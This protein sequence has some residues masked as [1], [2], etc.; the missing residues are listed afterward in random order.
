MTSNKKDYLADLHSYLV[1]ANSVLITSHK[2][3]DDDSISSVLALKLWIAREYPN[4]LVDIFYE[5]D[6]SQRWQVF[7]GFD[8]IYTV[9]SL[10]GS[11][12]DYDILICTDANQYH[13]LTD[14]PSGLTGYH[15]P[16]ICIDHHKS[17]PDAWDLLILDETAVATAEILFGLLYNKPDKK[18]AKALLLG[19]LG[20]TGNLR[21]IDHSQAYVYDIVKQLVS[22]AKIN[23]QSFKASYDYYS[24]AAI[25]VARHLIANQKTLQIKSW[26]SVNIT[27]VEG[28]SLDYL[29][30]EIKE[31]VNLYIATFSMLQQEVT[32]SIV[33]YE[34]EKGVNISARSIPESVNVRKFMENLGIGSGHDRAAGGVWQG[35]SYSARQQVEYLE[36]WLAS[37]PP[38]FD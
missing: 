19:I 17:Q 22:D 18:L 11:M 1:K 7:S 5:S 23:V 26:P 38:L 35:S 34:T 20:D 15:K 31:G 4:K 14:S 24:A 10:E 30:A 6:I 12:A 36:D 13:R 27:Y 37:H 2:S 33:L 32:W 9:D 21:F 28:A 8:Q 29:Q 16:K 3:P 25:E